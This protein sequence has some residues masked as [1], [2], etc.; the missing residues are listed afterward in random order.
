MEGDLYLNFFCSVVHDNQ[1][2]MTIRSS[3]SFLNSIN[4]LLEH[5]AIVLYE[6]VRPIIIDTMAIDT[7]CDLVRMIKMEIIAGDVI[8]RSFIVFLSSHSD[9]FTAVVIPIIVKIEE[10]IRERV[11][12]IAHIYI[13]SAI[14]NYTPTP[15]DLDYPAKLYRTG[16]EG[17]PLLEYYAQ[18][19]NKD[20]KCSFPL[21]ITPSVYSVW[22]TPV[23]KALHVLSLLY[24]CVDVV[25]S[26]LS[27]R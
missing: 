26:S 20:Y 22:Y 15:Q 1:Y 4:A 24:T 13:D 18:R 10:D 11:V 7:L 23:Q 25:S 3:P 21:P 6:S 5:I 16:S 2:I 12:Y 27:H 8:K 14:A 19:R 17:P 9:S